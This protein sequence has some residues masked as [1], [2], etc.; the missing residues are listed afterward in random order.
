MKRNLLYVLLVVSFLQIG[1]ISITD[2]CYNA[3]TSS[4]TLSNA[5][6][7]IINSCVTTELRF[8]NIDIDVLGNVQDSEVYLGAD[9]VY[10]DSAA[11]PDLDVSA[12]I[13]FR[14]HDFVLAPTVLRDGA[15]CPT[16]NVTHKR[17]EITV[18]VPGFSNYTL[19]HRQ[20]F[21]VFSDYEPEL[22]NK[23]YQ[24][25][26]LGDA[27]RNDDYSC[28]L[29]IFGKN[30][31]GELILVQTNPERK[32]VGNWLGDADQNQPESLGFFPTSKGVTN[33]YFRGNELHGYNDFQ[34]VITCSSTTEQRVY[35]ESIST[36]YS[37]AGRTLVSRGVWVTDD[38]NAFYLT[39]I[40]IGGLLAIWLILMVW[41]SLRFK[42]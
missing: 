39:I 18:E 29:Q 35:E 13:I 19:Q 22:K 7:N 40:I 34:M 32:A 28:L 6:L 4:G 2:S 12:I 23:V 31:R 27:R 9:W 36:R 1:F 42:N 20:D 11:R 38:E 8:S 41:R 17:G 3:S 24:V 10:V 26:D 14:N 16:C 33:T 5:N 37:P 15:T 21:Q 30:Q 25:V